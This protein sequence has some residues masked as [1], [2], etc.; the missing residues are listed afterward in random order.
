MPSLRNA[1]MGP[2]SSEQGNL[3]EAS[4]NLAW[5]DG[6]SMGPH[7]SEQGNAIKAA[8]LEDIADASMGPHSSEQGNQAR[9][10][11]G[12]AWEAASMGPHSSEQGNSMCGSATRIK[13]WCFNGASL[14]RA[15]KQE[16]IYVFR[17]NRLGFNGASLFRARKPVIRL[18]VSADMRASMGP[19]SSEQ[20]NRV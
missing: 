17:G 11:Q 4:G 13:T 19:H 20:G 2:H 5:H 16:N 9:L 7:S 1:S 3:L 14:F 6:A 10:A 15:R 12:I 8:E 18:R